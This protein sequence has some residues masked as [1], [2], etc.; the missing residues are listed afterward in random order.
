MYV[1]TDKG[2]VQIIYSFIGPDF[3]DGIN[4]WSAKD[5]TII[6]VSCPNIIHQYNKHMGAVDLCDMLMALHRVNV[7]TKKLYFHT[8]YY[9]I[10]VAIANAWL[11]YKRHCQQKNLSRSNTMQLLVFQTRIANSLLREKKR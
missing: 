9:C 2:M 1:W 7:S 11:I 10:N 4:H 5:T 3:G 6:N 8:I